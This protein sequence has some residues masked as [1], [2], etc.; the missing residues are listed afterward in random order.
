[1][2]N[3][4]MRGT[5]F[6]GWMVLILFVAGPVFAQL[7]TG[8]I[9]GTVKDSTGATVA[10]AT[11]TVTSADTGLTR[12]LTTGP[13]G[14][15]RFPAL[16]VGHYNIR[17]EHA[18][19]NT[20]AQNGLLLEVTQEAVVNFTLQ[21]GATTQ[22]VQVTAQSAQVDTTTSSL[23][24]LVNED[25]IADLPLNGRN[26]VDLTLLQPGISRQLNFGANVATTGTVYSSNGASTHSNMV[27]L[28]GAIMTTFSGAQPG[29]VTGSTLG[30]DGI[31]EY[32]VITN[33]FSAEYGL[34][35][36]SQS[37]I[38]SK[39]GTNQFHGDAFEYIR[40]DSLDARN[41][42]DVL[43]T[44][45]SNGCGTDKSVVYPCKRLPPYHR[46]NFGGSFGGP[47]QKDKTFVYGVYEGLRE[48]LGTTNTATT[49]AA[50]CKAGIVG[51]LPSASAPTALGATINGV[52]CPQILANQNVSP[53]VAQATTVKIGSISA[54]SAL[55][56]PLFPNPNVVGNK[57]FNYAYP[58]IQPNQE[59]YGQI[60]VDHIFSATDSFFVRYTIDNADLVRV[61]PY[62]LFL[63]P[64]LSENQFLTFS[65]NHI[66]S[67]SL[68]NTAR[69]SI[70]REPITGAPSPSTYNAPLL[71]PLYTFIQAPTNT[72]GGVTVTGL[73]AITP[74]AAGPQNNNQNAFTVSDDIFYTHGR[75]SFKFGTLMNYLQDHDT[76]HSLTKGTL[77]FTTSSGTLSPVGLFMEGKPTSIA[78]ATAQSNRNNFET[79]DV[80][81][82]Y[83]QDDLRASSRLTL[84]LGLRYEF[85]T[86]EIDR[87][88]HASYLPDPATSASFVIGPQVGNNASLKDLSPRLGFA[89]DVFGNGKTSVRSGFAVLYDVGVT[90]QS[91]QIGFGTASL[92]P[93]VT[94]FTITNPASF[95]IPFNLASAATTPTYQGEGYFQNQ[96]T[97][98][99]YNFG[100]QQQLPLNTV[101]SVTYVGTRGYNLF[102]WIESDPI[103][104]PFFGSVTN[105][106]GC[107]GFPAP[108]DDPNGWPCWSPNTPSCANVVPACRVNPNWTSSAIIA[109]APQQLPNNQSPTGSK[110]WYNAL[111]VGVNKR[112]SHGL[113]FQSSYTW[114]RSLDT[115]SDFGVSE[116]EAG[117]NLSPEDPNNA[118]FNSKGPSGFD[119]TQNWRFN[120]IYHLPRFI[121]A[122]H[123]AEKALNGWWVS[124]IVSL[125]TGYPF[126]PLISNN[127]SLSE[128]NS[129]AQQVGL[130]DRPDL[131]T[132][133]NLAGVRAC[134]VGYGCNPNAVVFNAH[135]AITGN[136]LQWFNPN[137]FVDPT[138][139]YLGNAGRG[140]M[141]GPGLTNLDFSLVK[142]TKVGFLGEAGTVQ[143]RAEIFNLL[144]H[145]NFALPATAYTVF[146]GSTT[147]APSTC[148]NAGCT[149]AA[150]SVLG[151]AGVIGS[152][153]ATPSRQIQLAL[154][155]IF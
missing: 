149:N 29:S 104:A 108:A 25:R 75:N 100:V 101:L 12:N 126:T 97:I 64:N 20:E 131:V 42:F 78:G 152:P 77:A 147:G 155:I 138:V 84:N 53:A 3:F 14:V 31:E 59:D 65:E 128:G 66:F 151:T 122:E 39:G 119:V 49:L 148:T 81:G 115:V 43:D 35:M 73:T 145:P 11:V 130:E 111:Q 142:D 8:T 86:Q 28:D 139:G 87:N 123:F 135:T 91:V 61:Q 24:G 46:N 113:E 48:Y 62:A 19:F 5:Y 102:H 136:P 51:I 9:L 36:G 95:A 99:E 71:G 37:V 60:R 63:T 107:N 82:F 13:D 134:S 52:Q 72:L 56:V 1:V 79:Y 133:A 105:G 146:G 10:G 125:Q 141:R 106:I 23:G 132:N 33:T 118:F 67:P 112:T 40:N 117:A 57:S 69:L 103:A 80:F 18:G 109:N 153:T 124:S 116:G 30:V 127:R 98:M 22:E 154:K 26:F 16:P 120:V 7:P 150:D 32:K 45:N 88:N 110:S 144:N 41:Y 68:L 34:T 121:G 47:I 58:F 129:N 90:L 6:C 44:S 4:A 85:H 2:K 70:S 96:P 55:L 89:W 27:Y 137:M 143:F 83:V 54:A 140:I 21:V 94:K 93:Y 114:S 50:G 76:G 74:D 38:V 17:T 92:P 15:Y